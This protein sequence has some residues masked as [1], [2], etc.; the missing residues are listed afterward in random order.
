ME[1]NPTNGGQIGD[2]IDPYG[3]LR[4]QTTSVYDRNSTYDLQLNLPC[5]N[6]VSRTYP[7]TT[8]DVRNLHCISS[9]GGTDVSFDS[10][11]NQNKVDTLVQSPST[12]NTQGYVAPTWGPADGA[13]AGAG[14]NLASFCS[15]TLTALCTSTSLRGTLAG[16]TRPASGAWD[17]GAYFVGAGA[18]DPPSNVSASAH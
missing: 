18:P 8:V 13:T 16:V 14:T 6:V 2:E 7:M 1:S 11:T 3:A 5:V 10:T 9:G 17:I 15:G 12:A 4:G